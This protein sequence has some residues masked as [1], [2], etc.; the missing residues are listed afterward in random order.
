MAKKKQKTT[1]TLNLEINDILK[2]LNNGKFHVE[3]PSC[4]EESTE[5]LELIAE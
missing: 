1:D 5:L 2:E 3:C 4:Y